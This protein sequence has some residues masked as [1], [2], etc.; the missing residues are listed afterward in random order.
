[1]PD[2]LVP[3]AEFRILLAL[4]DGPKHGHAIRLDVRERTEGRVDMGPGT[5][6]GAIKRLDRRGWIEEVEANGGAGDA[7]GR[8]RTY[9]LTREGRQAARSEVARLEELL[10]IARDKAL[11]PAG[12]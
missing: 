8:K 7:D 11:R 4:V 2:D 3:P 6:Y 12:G 5:L 9:R 10:G 1:M